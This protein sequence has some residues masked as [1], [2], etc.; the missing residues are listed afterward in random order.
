VKKAYE[1]AAFIAYYFHWDMSDI[2][3]M[4]HRDRLKWCEEISSIHQATDDK[5]ERNLFD[6]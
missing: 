2:L 4:E 3:Q 5:Q 6:L 1:E